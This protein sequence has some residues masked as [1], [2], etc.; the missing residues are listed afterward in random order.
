MLQVVVLMGCGMAYQAALGMC[1]P[2]YARFA[3]ELGLGESIGGLVL[4][5]PCVA[6]VALNLMLGS[7]VD[8]V[9]RKPLLIGGSLV[10]AVGAYR[11][12]SATSMW[13]MIAGRLLVGAGGAASEIAAQACK[14]DVVAH[15]PSRRGMLLGWA[16][17]LTILAYAA[18][19]VAGGYLSARL[20]VRE[21]FYVFAHTLVATSILYLLLPAEKATPAGVKAE[22]MAAGTATGIIGEKMS[23]APHHGPTSST[24]SVD[25]GA[26]S[27]TGSA[28]P[29]QSAAPPPPQRSGLV[30]RVLGLGMSGEAVH[31]LLDDPRQLALLLFRFTITCGWAS[32]MIVLP[33][34]LTHTFG[35]DTPAI[36]LCLSVMTLAGFAF[37]PIGGG[38]ADRLG[39]YRVARLGAVVSAAALGVMPCARRLAAV[40]ALL[41][42][43]EV[44]TAATSAATAAA[45]AAA[46]PSELRGLQSSLL[47]QVQDVTFA[48]MPFALGVLAARIGTSAT[49]GLTAVLQIGTIAV[50]ARMQTTARQRQRE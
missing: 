1:M 14:L 16:H 6:R 19:P 23:P 8:N 24:S 7:L 39:A 27:C 41:A 13:S 34:H 30:V 37:S 2:L 48:V 26:A 15:F 33:A 21:P 31:R 12:A 17:A 20:G 28:T 29:L 3:E 45:A 47:G 35:L 11:T 18:G 25:A 38:L 40:W 5:A 32:W 44:G 9:G 49:L 46:T 4:A 36:G 42:V 50:A 22:A 10:M 43:W